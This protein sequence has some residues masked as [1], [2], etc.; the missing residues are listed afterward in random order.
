MVQDLFDKII[1]TAD[2]MKKEA[3]DTQDRYENLNY[4]VFAINI[5]NSYTISR[6]IFK[7]ILCRYYLKVNV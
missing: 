4:K 6:L 2:D 3:K 1:K 7:F 5:H